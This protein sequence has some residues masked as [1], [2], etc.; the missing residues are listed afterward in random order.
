VIGQARGVDDLQLPADVGYE[1]PDLPFH[2]TAVAPL[3]LQRRELADVPP[4]RTF[5]NNALIE[6]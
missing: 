2:D 1:C 6:T 4:R 5:M 3:R